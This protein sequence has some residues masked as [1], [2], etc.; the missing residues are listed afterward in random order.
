MFFYKIN[1]LI[2]FLWLGQFYLLYLLLNSFL[3]N[4]LLFQNL[5]VFITNLFK[6]VYLG[7]LGTCACFLGALGLP[8]LLPDA[9]LDRLAVEGP[10]LAP[11]GAGRFAHGRL[12]QIS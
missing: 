7:H 6:I 5:K 8:V 10:P 11:P 2:Y 3:T 1:N 12:V 4:V 9:F